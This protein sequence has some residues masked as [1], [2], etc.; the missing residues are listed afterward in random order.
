MVSA[1]QRTFRSAFLALQ[2]IIPEKC[3]SVQ[4]VGFPN[5]ADIT[6]VTARAKELEAAMDFMI[7]QAND[8]LKAKGNLISAVGVKK[9]VVQLFKLKNGLDLSMNCHQQICN[10]DLE[11]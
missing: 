3:D 2:K 8:S 7:P 6:S 1:R 4:W 9:L 10:C 5:L 11:S